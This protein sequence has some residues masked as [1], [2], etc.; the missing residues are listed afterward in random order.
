[1]MPNDN[2]LVGGAQLGNDNRLVGWLETSHVFQF[3]WDLLFFF[4]EGLVRKFV[5]IPKIDR[6]HPSGP[7]LQWL[8]GNGSS[9]VG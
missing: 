3:T 5:L 6:F 1:M 7:Q 8:Q 4:Q 9:M 2:R